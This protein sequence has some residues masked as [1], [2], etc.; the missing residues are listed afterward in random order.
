M[1][2]TP[3][4]LALQGAVLLS[5]VGGTTAFATLDKDLTV[6]VDGETR[7]VSSF[8]TTVAGVLDREG[9]EVD[10]HDTVVPSLDSKVSEGDRIVVRNGRL[11]TLR[12]DGVER[13][14][15]TTA[16]DVDEALSALGMRAE[17]AFVSAS[18]S[19]RIPLG[20][21]SIDLRLPKAV[22]V[23]VDG[24]RIPVTSS[25]ATVG[26]V[27]A[28][29][30]VSLA[31]TDRLAPAAATPLAAGQAI[32]VTRVRSKQVQERVSIAYATSRRADSDLYEGTSKVLRAGRA[33]TKV[34]VYTDVL[35]DGRR[36]GRTKV[37]EV[38]VERPV[39]KIV[40]YGTKDR[41]V[42]RATSAGSSS[43][44]GSTSSSKRRSTGSAGLNW[45]A[46]AECESGGN[47]R[48]VSSNGLYH[49]LY[50]FSVSTWESVGGSGLPSRAS[51]SEQTYR[52][53]LL[54]DRS[55]ASP[56]PTCGRR[57]FS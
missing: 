56:W 4:T 17:G 45:A 27:V 12:I 35:T 54:Y 25:A 16:D 2:F 1:R 40:A 55:G 52:A 19:R 39:S 11:L 21:L 44:S 41:P 36:T 47:P 51:S 53:Q 43:G 38:L 31:P 14:V 26:E 42:R 15:W 22:V 32:R 28:Q 20:G 33:G 6:S 8:A 46:L 5:L 34:V 18:R 48:I 57:L 9:I 7:E 30:G 49:G 50:Q 3:T 10:G 24:R 23:A 37:R 13:Q 29:A